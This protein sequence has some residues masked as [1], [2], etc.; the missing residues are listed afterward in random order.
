MTNPF[1]DTEGTC[2]FHVVVNEEGQHALWP[3][4]AAVP[5]GWDVVWGEGTRADALA[6][7][8]ENWRDIRPKSLVAQY[9]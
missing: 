3:V 8:E 2:T 9:A 6:Y 4:F 1:D 5:A 7:V